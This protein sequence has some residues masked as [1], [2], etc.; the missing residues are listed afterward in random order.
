MVRLDNYIHTLEGFADARSHLAPG[1]IMYVGYWCPEP[2]IAER[3]YQ[4][5]TLA[6]GHPPVALQRIYDAAGR[7]VV[8][9]HFLIGDPGVMPALQQLSGRWPEYPAMSLD[10]SS[11]PSTDDWPYLALR[12]RSVPPLMLLISLAILIVSVSAAARARPRGERFDGRLFFMGAAF[13]L[14]EVHNVSKLALVFGST[15]QVNAWVVAAIM[16]VVLLANA[17]QAH[18]DSV[19]SR[20]RLASPAFLFAAL[21]V[22]AWLPIS[23][24]ITRTALLGQTAAALVLAMPVFFAALLFART[25]CD[26]ASPSSALGWNI[27]GAVVGGLAGNLSYVSGISG[28]VYAVAVFYAIALLWRPSAVRPGSRIAADG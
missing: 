14:L 15:W 9:A 3:L 12:D 21:A 28:L 27:L 18:G 23:L 22:C 4:N 10:G 8:E 17:L 13:M 25:F 20:W 19:I 11:A 1:G 16:G 26:S 7:Q 6:F 2:F 5:L 24:F